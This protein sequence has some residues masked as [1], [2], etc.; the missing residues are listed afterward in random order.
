VSGSD[1]L[2]VEQVL[3]D[4]EN[5]REQ[6]RA[7]SA[8][9]RA[10]ARSKGL[11][12]VLDEVVAA[13]TRLCAGDYGVL[14]LVQGGL[15]HAVSQRGSLETW[16]Y[17]KDNPH[18]ID[19][20]SVVGRAAL[21]RAP[22]HIPDILEDPD[23]SYAGPHTGFRAMLGVPI[24]DEHDLIGTMAI[25]RIVP[26]PFSEDEIELVTTFANQAA[27]AIANGRLID[28]VERQLE[29]QRGISDV[30]RATA[31][32]QGLESVLEVVVET[33]AR[34]CAADY[35][36]LFL[37]EGQLL[38]V[39][40]NY[41]ARPEVYDY[42]KAHPHVPERTS[43]VG[44]V[45]LTRDVVHIPDV[46]ADPEYVH[47]A[48]TIGGYRAML[49]VPIFL[50]VELTGVVN[51]VRDLPE[52]FTDDQIELVRTFADQ[53]AI[54][55]ANARLI[56]A[57]ERQRTE[58]SRFVSPQVAELVSSDEGEKMLGGHRAYIS[59]LFC[60]LRG[61]TAFTETAEPEELFEVLREYHTALGELIPAHEGTL[62]HFAGDGLMVFFNDPLAV[63]EHEL[64]A[65]R[66][67]LAAHERFAELASQW[68]KRGTELGLGIGI[69]AGYATLGRIGFEG[70]YDYGALGPVTNLASRLSTQAEPGQTLIAQRVFAAVEDAVEA[71]PVS[72]LE[73]KGFGRPVIAYEVRGLS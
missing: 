39:A 44:R 45:A 69:A 65:I 68:R 15:L 5:L 34:L 28:A 25:T 46:L 29:Q 50:D 35:G 63:Q 54:A 33:V 62:E 70:R 42:E 7:I 32:S 11:Q 60:D 38:V 30:L 3:R 9:L 20:T 53:A 66:L 43:C 13:T 61:F 26:E 17:D 14:F 36:E 55:I 58:L 40:A 18:E 57:V 1:T 8:V 6:Q 47:P 37:V 16:E 67:A 21:T 59:A 2:D 52:P 24:L 19:R 41:G 56:H 4:N 12:P 10:V 71:E 72:E 73:L 48:Q 27:I 22:A 31:R 51:V 23:Y 64:K 49:G